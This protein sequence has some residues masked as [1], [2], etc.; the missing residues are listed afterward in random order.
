MLSPGPL[1][2]FRCL[3]DSMVCPIRALLVYAYTRAGEEEDD[4]S[5]RRILL[6][7]SWKDDILGLDII[8]IRNFSLLI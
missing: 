5:V 7:V 3:S 4:T 1:V 2:L 8:E 6:K